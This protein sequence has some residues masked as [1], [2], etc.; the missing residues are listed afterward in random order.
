MRPLSWCASDDATGTLGYCEHAE[1]S[2]PRLAFMFGTLL[3][4]SAAAASCC[5]PVFLEPQ[6][7]WSDPVAQQA[8]WNTIMHWLL[9]AACGFLLVAFPLLAYGFVGWRMERRVRD[10]E[11][12]RRPRR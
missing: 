6:P 12:S 9:A 3:L 11:R 7:P 8:Q 2:R 10:E 1:V 4:V 5:A